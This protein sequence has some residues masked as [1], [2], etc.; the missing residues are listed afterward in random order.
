MRQKV[1]PL[2]KQ[3]KNT[4]ASLSK[5]GHLGSSVKYEAISLHFMKSERTQTWGLRMCRKVMSVQPSTDKKKVEHFELFTA[6]NT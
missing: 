1:N 2:A 6:P 5:S 4:S 3:T